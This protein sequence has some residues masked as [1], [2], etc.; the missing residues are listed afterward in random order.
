MDLTP[1]MKTHPGTAHN[2]TTDR[3]MLEVT[4]TANLPHIT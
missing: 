3:N 1:A 4:A 2:L